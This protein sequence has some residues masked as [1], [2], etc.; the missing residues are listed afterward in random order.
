MVIGS[1]SVAHR[2]PVT[3]GI[4]NSGDVQIVNG[5]GATDLVIT[6]GAY[7]LD[8]GTKVKVGPVTEEGAPAAGKAKGDD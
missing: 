4:T 8:E 1:D 6:T 5:L 3:L 7:G 2:R